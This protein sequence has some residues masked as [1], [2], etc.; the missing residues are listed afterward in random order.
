MALN[1]NYI[2]VDGLEA[3]FVDKSTG[4]PLAGGIVNFYED[5]NRTIGKLV[6]QLTGSPPN[7]TYTALPNPLILSNTGTFQDAS[8]NNIAVYFF[9]YDINRN[10]Q[11]YYVTVTDVLGTQQFTREGWPFSAITTSSSSAT[12][13][14]TNQIT[15]PQFVDISFISPLTITATVAGTLSVSIAPSWILNLTTSGA[16]SV[17]VTRNSIAGTAA[18]P[19]NPPY[20][21]TITPGANVTALTLSQNLANNPDIWS[22]QTGVAANGWI[23]TSLLLANASSATISYIPSVGAAQVLLVANNT[24]GVYQEFNGTVQLT[25][26]VNTDTSTVGYV[27][28]VI[29]LLTV[30]AT[31]L[32]N[33]QVLPL[34]TNI[35]NVT[36]NETSVNQQRNQLFNYYNPLLQYKPT[37]SYL[38]GWDFALNPAQFLGNNVAPI[39]T[40]ANTSNYYWDQ[41]IIFQSVD[42]G[43]SIS[44]SAEGNQALRVTANTTTQ[45][46]LIQ[47]IS[48]PLA[49][50]ILQNPLSVN[51]AAIS[52]AVG[53]LVG[54]ISL[55]YTDVGLPSTVT[56]HNSIV[57]SL[58]ATGKPLTFNGSWLEVPRN[59]MTTTPIYGT[60]LLGDAV[61][62]ATTSSNKNFND[63]GFNGWTMNG[64]SDINT[65][66]YVAI[67]IGF[68]SLPIGKYIDISSISLTPGYIPTRPAPT[69]LS[70]D[71]LSECQS[72]YEK[73]FNPGVIPA[74]SLPVSSGIFAATTTSYKTT[75]ANPYVFA[76]IPFKVTKYTV[77]SAI[78]LYSPTAPGNQLID[79]TIPVSF[80][81]TSIAYLSQNGFCVT[82]T[83]IVGGA[84]VQG[85]TCGVGWAADCRLGY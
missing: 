11:L 18:Y 7:Y 56:S 38:A 61:F 69:V 60:S 66:T 1:S 36:Y 45:F 58:N 12:G 85:D 31:T 24:G 20:T 48:S 64:D 33:V 16:G 21:L 72:Y 14:F 78:T 75:T 9:P 3:Y 2:T 28:I 44:R 41:T 6:Y 43:V 5:N 26:P 80:T 8:G 13:S 77:P 23:A 76:Y 37:N 39:A 47:Y 52:N 19:F 74:D 25:A 51:I 59:G 4:Q 22:P 35:S 50:E 84:D 70:G 42:S 73:S 17:T 15:N 82:F 68:S 34:Q 71:V 27:D 53:G 30:V 65:P 46:A 67:V 29:T 10:L 32:S 40:G 55:W 83:G 49:E 63:Y 79:L 54:T 62:L 81:G 57:K